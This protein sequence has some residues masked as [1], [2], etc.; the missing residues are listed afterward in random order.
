MGDLRLW[1][2]VEE[3]EKDIMHRVDEAMRGEEGKERR[4]EE[5]MK[6]RGRGSLK[7][8]NDPL[9][10]EGPKLQPQTITEPENQ[11]CV[12]PAC[13]WASVSTWNRNEQLYLCSNF[14]TH[15]PWNTPTHTHIFEILY[16]IWTHQLHSSLYYTFFLW[17]E[18]ILPVWYSQETCHS[19]IRAKFYQLSGTFLTSLQIIN[20]TKN[21][22]GC[23]I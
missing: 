22:Q 2:G 11:S 19:W 4:G 18:E 21:V 17:E 12:L 14:W 6:E 8:S 13:R 20:I 5:K 23:K 1:G 10:D 9:I 16:F 3:D 7:S 15:T